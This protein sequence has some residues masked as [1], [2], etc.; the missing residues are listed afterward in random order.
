MSPSEIVAVPPIKWVGGKR[1]LIP[2]I[3]A[4]LPPNGW[5]RYHEWFAGGLAMFFHLWTNERAG[6]TMSRVV[7]NDTN[8]RLMAMYRGLQTDVE[9]VIRELE[10]LAADCSVT[11]YKKAVLEFNRYRP[12]DQS[13][14]SLFTAPTLP[15]PRQAALLIFIIRLCFNGLYRENGQGAYNVGYCKNPEQFS[16]RA[17]E[18]RIAALALRSACLYDGDFSQLLA[19]A[20]C[21]DFVFLDPPYDATFT[22]YVSGSFGPADQERLA[23]VC[24]ELDMRGVHWLM[25]NSDTPRVRKLWER[26]HL[27]ESQETRSVNSDG[28]DRGPVGC[29][30]LRNYK[31]AA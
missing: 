27:V 10:K 3:E 30:I 24:N 14:V 29:L 23:R 2:T 6:R 1:Q 12:F 9:A 19:L 25:T 16:V 28:D 15:L 21:G 17:D 18:L 31:V 13:T 7:I 22:D 11:G 4:Q 26:F 5:N 8:P 20:E